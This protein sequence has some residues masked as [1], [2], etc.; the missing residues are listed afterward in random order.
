MVRTLIKVVVVKIGFLG[1]TS[2]M[3]ALL[4]ERAIRKDISIRSISTG[5][6]MGIGDVIDVIDKAMTWIPDVLILITPNIGEPGPKAGVKILSRMNILKIIISDSSSNKFSQDLKDRGWGYFLINGDVM[7]GAQRDFLDPIEMALFNSDIIKIL[8]VT[9]VFRLLHVRLDK[10]I[11]Q[12]GRSE[13]VELPHII[14]DDGMAIKYAQ[15]F[16]PYA[17]AK[18]LASYRIA[19]EAGKLA[20]EGCFIVKE[21]ERCLSLVAAAHEL[22][23]AAAILADEAREIEKSNDTIIR[24]VHDDNGDLHSKT[25]FFGSL[26][27][28]HV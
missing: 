3:E 14:V 18:A 21:R 10:I 13:I 12:V 9:G 16:N 6:K 15:F 28:E 8:A 11:E 25:H 4:D 24:K 5:S 1:S 26:F 17:Q 7:I 19:E 22:I 23:R 2:L 27:K 20:F